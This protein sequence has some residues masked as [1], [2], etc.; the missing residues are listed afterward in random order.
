[1]TPYYEHAGI[2]IYHGSALDVLPHVRF[3]VNVTITDP[4]YNVGLDYSSG[5]NRSDYLDW[6]RRWVGHA[7]YPLIVTPGMV[8]LAMWFRMAEPTW[9]CAWLKPNQCSPSRLQGFNV[10]EP[11]LVYGRVRKPVGHDAWVMSIGTNQVDAETHPCPKW[12]PFWTQL[13][14]RFT[15]PDDLVLDPFMG[16]GTTLIAAKNLGRKAIGIDSDEQYCEIAAKRLAQDV[17]AFESTA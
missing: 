17:F 6:T 3:G 4:P 1:V 9:I 8:N 12:L 11:I 5:D 10:W 7:P 16:S 14:D 15:L 13:V 2:T